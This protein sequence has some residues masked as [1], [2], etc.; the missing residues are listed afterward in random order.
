MSIWATSLTKPVVVAKDLFKQGVTDISWSKDG[1]TV[2][3]CSTEGTVCAL[4]LEKEELGQTIPESEFNQMIKKHYGDI[5]NVPTGMSL[6]ESPAQLDMERRAVSQTQPHTSPRNVAAKTSLQP[7]ASNKPPQ[8]I[9]QLEI[10]LPG[11]NLNI[12]LNADD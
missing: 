7:P 12:Q 11:K 8:P 4:A 9:K 3:C 10:R 1:Y 6:A 2:L 5:L